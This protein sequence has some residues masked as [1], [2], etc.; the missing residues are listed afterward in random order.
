MYP[1]EVTNQNASRYYNNDNKT[2][3]KFFLST[4]V[5]GFK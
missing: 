4:I 1:K 2:N 5:N 3:Y